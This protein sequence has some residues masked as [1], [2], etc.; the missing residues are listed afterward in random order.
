MKRDSSNPRFWARWDQLLQ[1]VESSSVTLIA[2]L[3]PNGQMGYANE[4][5]CWGKHFVCFKGSFN[6]IH[7]GHVS[8]FNA[9]LAK[10]NNSSGAFALSFNTSKRTLS[11][12]DL[13]FR[14]RLIH[15]A[16][17]RVMVSRSGRFSHIAEF[18][19]KVSPSIQLIFPLG[20]DVLLR[21]FSYYELSE[22]E[23]LFQNSSFEYFHR[24]GFEQQLPSSF[25]N[26]PRA[27]LLGDNPH[28]SVTS[29]KLWQLRA[30]EAG[31][32]VRA[33]M[34]AGA[35]EHFL[36]VAPEKPKMDQDET[37]V[38]AGWPFLPGKKTFGAVRAEGSY[39]YLSDGRRILDA[40]GG[41]G[42]VNV[43]H[44]RAEVVNTIS[45]SLKNL[46]YAVP[47]FAT[48]ERLT[49][50]EHLQK[51]WLPEGLSRVHLLGSG[52]DA[53]EAAV[54]LARKYQVACG[55][56]GRWKTIGRDVS[57]HGSTLGS[58]A[59]GGHNGRKAGLGPLLPEFSQAPA[60]YC[61]RCPFNQTFPECNISCA[62]ALE[63]LISRE[64]V[65]TIA[66]FIAE[67]IVGASGG[68]LTP[69]DEY[70]PII[71]GIC[72]R[73]NIVLI[74][75]EITTG[76]G[77]TGKRFAVEFWDVRPDILVVGKGLTGGY[78]P[79]SAIFASETLVDAVASL[80]MNL[81]AHTFDGHGGS[82]AAA[83]SVLEIILREELLDRVRERGKMLGGSLVA[84]LANHSA[85]AEIRG[86]GLLW[87]IEIVRDRT[88]LERYPRSA[89]ITRRIINTGIEMG[90]FFYPGG[91]STERDIIVLSPPFI[92]E[93]EE[94]AEMVRVL[95]KA[96]N[97]VLGSQS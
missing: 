59:I 66:A 4:Q 48:P 47:G 87:A 57:Y 13:L 61:L 3:E 37:P 60:C 92:I 2:L 76:F 90:V 81:T 68:A 19:W 33:L 63:E 15:L 39:L 50:I 51:H 40:A 28:S 53:V 14:T 23:A 67:P 78:A 96:I 45:R 34:P 85:V 1:D 97:Q 42:V 8:L 10:R 18:F 88:T 49:L 29:S 55:R 54:M 65:E 89:N 52:S 94:I 75:D 12:E 26:Y 22:F 74:A 43:G 93:P 11:R 7:N 36:S 5:S 73:H 24:E 32:E 41:G 84:T 30:E 44:K 72:Q 38:S 58:L 6:P 69:P 21:L 16:G 62:H 9:A 20:I 83:S 91:T 80:G 64:G 35:A 17:Y 56:L 27:S 25:K 71:Q 95:K 86:R 46:S 79:L 77:R 82:C 70:W 31:D